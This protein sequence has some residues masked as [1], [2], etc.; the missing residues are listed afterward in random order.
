[1]RVE[2]APHPIPPHAVLRFDL[3][4]G[5]GG[6]GC[7]VSWVEHCR[8][9]AAQT[10]DIWDRD[11]RRGDIRDRRFKTP[12]GRLAGIFHGLW[13]ILQDGIEVETICRLD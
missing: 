10:V 3:A 8:S 11:Q 6:P 1:M 5:E 9:H 4:W 2:T 13:C 12:P 7:V